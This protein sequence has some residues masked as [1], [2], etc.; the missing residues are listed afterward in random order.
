[1]AR[2]LVM[3][4]DSDFAAMLSGALEGVGHS[5]VVTGDGSAAMTA[6]RTSRYDL[7]ITDIYVRQDGQSTADGGIL[8]ISRIRSPGKAPKFEWMTTMRILAI[9]GA[10]AYR[11]PTQLTRLA[12]SIGA[13]R[14]LLKPMHLDDLLTTVNELISG[15]KG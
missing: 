12:E 6:L 13:D 1:M 14:A 2:I 10:R 5:V 11:D 9:T 7:L 8:L 4:D 15:G 3:E